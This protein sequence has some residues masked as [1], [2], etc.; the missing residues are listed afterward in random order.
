MELIK[1]KRE[2]AMEIATSLFY[3]YRVIDLTI[4]HATVLNHVVSIKKMATHEKSI[5]NNCMHDCSD[6]LL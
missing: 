5:A 6:H 1:N 2:V 3:I 4:F